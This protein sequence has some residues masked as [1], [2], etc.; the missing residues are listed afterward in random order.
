MDNLQ[1]QMIT[2]I[3]ISGAPVLAT[4]LISSINELIEQN[5]KLTKLTDKL[6]N[7]EG[8]N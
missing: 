6:K 8:G 5:K 2:K 3:I 7:K 4:E 1:Y